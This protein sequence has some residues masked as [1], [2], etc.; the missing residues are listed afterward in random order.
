MKTLLILLLLITPCFADEPEIVD[1]GSPTFMFIDSADSGFSYL[2]ASPPSKVSFSHEGR[3]IGE[4]DFSTGT[5]VF[6]GKAEE[7]AKIFFD[8][9]IKQHLK[10]VE[11]V[12]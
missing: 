10:C 6:E 9:V 12:K 4:L 1:Y 7:S 2:T 3:K 5:M 8:Y 11:D